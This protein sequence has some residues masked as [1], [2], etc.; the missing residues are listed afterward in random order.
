MKTKE[1]RRLNL[2]YLTLVY[3]P[4][5]Q[6]KLGYPVADLW[7]LRYQFLM[8]LHDPRRRLNRRVSE[9]IF[10]M[11]VRATDDGTLVLLPKAEWGKIDHVR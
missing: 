5:A 11:A 10:R 6:R 7:E 2:D 1:D 4:D 8:V 9:Q 3:D